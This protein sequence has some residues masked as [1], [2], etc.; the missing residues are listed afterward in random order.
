MASISFSDD[1]NHALQ[2]GQSYGTIGVEYHLPPRE[3]F[4]IG[5][6]C[7]LPIEAAAAREML[8]ECFG[9]L[10]SQESTDLNTYTLGR[11]GKHN[12]VIACPPAGEYGTTLATT[13]ANNMIRRFSKSLRVGLIVGTGGGLPSATH[14][15]RLGDI[16]ISTPEGH[17][18]GVRQ[19]DLGKAGVG[20]KFHQIGSLNSPPRL[21]LN[22]MVNMRANELRNNL[23]YPEYVRSAIKRTSRTQKIFTRPSAHHDRL[24]KANYD[25]SA[26][27]DNCDE[28]PTDWEETR[29]E[30]ESNNPEA[31]YGIIAS[32]NYIIKDGRIREQLRLETGALCYETEA[33]GLT[34]DFPCIVIRGISDYADSH[35]NKQ[36]QGYAALAAASYTKEL[37]GYIPVGHDV[38]GS[39]AVDV[40]SKYN[41][42]SD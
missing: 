37:L 11:I 12:I 21:L 24:F 8:D 6:I 13:V 28:C 38:Q 30:R 18:G 5:W 2:V 40:F 25:H 42:P 16:V 26:K 20:S 35:R 29:S 4:Q 27:M 22:A 32:G 9:D 39:L 3:A 10:D 31:H 7:A 19:Y 17:Y 14:D 15:I 23:Q 1:N 33:A 41:I 34:T 36:W